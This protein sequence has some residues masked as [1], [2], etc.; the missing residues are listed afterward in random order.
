MWNSKKHRGMEGEV[1]GPNMEPAILSVEACYTRFPVSLGLSFQFSKQPHFLE[2]VGVIWWYQINIRRFKHHCIC[3]NCRVEGSMYKF[4]ILRSLY[5]T[6]FKLLFRQFCLFMIRYAGF[7]IWDDCVLSFA[8]KLLY[9][10]YTLRKYPLP[11]V[12]IVHSMK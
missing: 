9:H 1:G 11:S 6:M 5:R 8:F 10:T 7:E 3:M 4:I 2:E 12:R